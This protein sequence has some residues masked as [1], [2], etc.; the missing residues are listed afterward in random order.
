MEK[1]QRDNRR[2]T[3]FVL[4]SGLLLG[5]SG[6]VELEQVEDF[7]AVRSAV[8][9]HVQAQKEDFYYLAISNESGL[10]NKLTKSY[11]DLSLLAASEVTVTEDESISSTVEVTESYSFSD[12]QDT[13]DSGDSEQAEEGDDCSE[14]P[15]IMD[16]AAEYTSWLDDGTHILNFY[17]SEGDQDWVAPA[18][19]S[20]DAGEPGPDQGPAFSSNLIYYHGNPYTAFL[21][22]FDLDTCT[23]DSEAY[24]EVFESY[25]MESGTIELLVPGDNRFEGTFQG[26]L[27]TL[28]DQLQATEK[29]GISGDFTATLC[30]I[31]VDTD[32]AASL[33]MSY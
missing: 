3:S 12:S 8:L 15:P 16:L 32:Y 5:C 7:G 27:L 29:G 17:F 11:Q 20:Y 33:D 21:G 22:A 18:E 13:G 9:A 30:E 4:L 6:T 19:G 26:Q 14:Y 28:D 24:G 31:P 1:H 23:L 2:N 10:C 25:Y